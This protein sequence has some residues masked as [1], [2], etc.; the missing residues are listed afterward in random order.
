MQIFDVL[1]WPPRSPDLNPMDHLWA[2]MKRELN[3]YPTPTKG[4]LQLGEHVVHSIT[5][6]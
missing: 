4:M 3:E 2:L 6:E 1:A 5:Q